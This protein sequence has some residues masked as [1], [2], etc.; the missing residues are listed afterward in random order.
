MKQNIKQL[1][2]SKGIT[3]RELSFETG[4]STALICY[5]SQGI[6]RFPEAW[7]LLTVCEQLG[8]KP[9]DLYT[10]NELKRF[11]PNEFPTKKREPS[12]TVNVKV[13]RVTAEIIQQT[14]GDINE[15]V[16]KLLNKQIRHD[17]ME[18]EGRYI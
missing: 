12:K 8:C 3:M 13:D 17:L 14:H 7:Q 5:I 18:E 15:L 2:K 1:M 10:K 9:T 16:R 4:L 11:Y 6:A